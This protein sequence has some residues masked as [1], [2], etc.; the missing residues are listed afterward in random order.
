MRWYRRDDMDLL[1]A[2]DPVF[3]SDRL[4]DLVDEL[5]DEQRY[6]VSRIFFGGASVTDVA[7][8]LNIK[9]YRAKVQLSRAFDTL[10]EAVLQDH[11]MGPLRTDD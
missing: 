7:A 6:L 10:R 9:Q 5:P 3:R 4:R 8:E 2:A 1:P 11:E